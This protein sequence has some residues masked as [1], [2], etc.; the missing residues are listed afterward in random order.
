VL[1]VKPLS[2]RLDVA[3]AWSR[4]PARRD[5]GWRELQQALRPARPP[6]PAGGGNG[7]LGEPLA[8]N[9]QLWTQIPTTRA[10]LHLRALHGTR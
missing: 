7:E 1:S 10:L 8:V 2:N 4:R 9:L 3:A 6:R 5:C